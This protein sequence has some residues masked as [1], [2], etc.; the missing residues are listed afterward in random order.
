MKDEI[1]Q[2]AGA[3]WHGLHTHGELSIAQ[4]KKLVEGK[5][6][7]FDWG[8]RLAGTRGQNRDNTKEAILQ[9]PIQINAHRL[10]R[11]NLCSVCSRVPL[12]FTT[13]NFRDPHLL[14]NSCPRHA[15]FVTYPAF[16]PT[17]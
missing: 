7:L 5:A 11:P 10:G 14:N 17:V 8:H 6:P 2:M 4:L 16:F 9:H 12:P 3:I 13:R 15:E 1:G